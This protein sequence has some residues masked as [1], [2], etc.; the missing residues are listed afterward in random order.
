MQIVEKKLWGL[1]SFATNGTDISIEDIRNNL[2]S[3]LQ[4]KYRSDAYF[5]D[6][7]HDSCGT[8][9]SED[10]WEYEFKDELQTP[11]L[12]VYMYIETNEWPF[13]EGVQANPGQQGV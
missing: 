11:H 4:D 7:Q 6:A 2:L 3:Q 9:M 5:L 1:P 12:H 13:I 10:A 8:F